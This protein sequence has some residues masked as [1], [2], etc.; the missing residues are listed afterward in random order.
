MKFLTNK[1]YSKINLLM[2]LL[3]YFLVADSWKSLKESRVL[4]LAHEVDR[5][6]CFEGKKYSPLIDSIRHFLEEKKINCT[7]ISKPFNKKN[8]SHAYYGDK[9]L[10]RIFLFNFLLA[11]VISLATGQSF[12][13]VRLRRKI[14]IWTKILLIVKPKVVIGIQPDE[15]LCIV[16]HQSGIAIYDL[17]HGKIDEVS[18]YYN[19]ESNAIKNKNQ[20]PTGYL[21]WNK[22]SA[23]QLNGWCLQKGIQVIILG[24][25]WLYR[26][27]HQEN[28][29]LLVKGISNKQPLSPSKKNILITLQWGMDIYYPQFFSQK[30]ILHPALLEAIKLSENQ[31]NWFIRLHPVQLKNKKIL[32]KMQDL[33]ANNPNVDF[34]W[35]STEAL[36]PVLATVHAHITWDSYTVVEAALF[37]IKSYVI[38]PGRVSGIASSSK[39]DSV[40]ESSSELPYL[41]EEEEGFITRTQGIPNAQ[42]IMHWI[43]DG[44][45]ENDS[46]SK[47]QLSFDKDKLYTIALAEFQGL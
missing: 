14:K 8:F 18:P 4:L 29:D 22:E 6:F 2:E 17:Q 35:S 36:P 42:S 38:N 13:S 31:L 27:K 37:G 30:D 32:K 9:T 33:F 19:K 40:D 12:R 23:S 34:H 26:F 16:C 25:P 43:N 1:L 20:L 11:K 5:F 39:P 44:D 46:V 3:R 41:K 15:A 21:C 7:G 10:N 45:L 47:L 28:T 24:N